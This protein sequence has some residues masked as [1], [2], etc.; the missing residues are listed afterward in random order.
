MRRKTRPDQRYQAEPRRIECR[1][2]LCSQCLVDCQMPFP[3]L[4]SDAAVTAGPCQQGSPVLRI[5]R[6]RPTG[7]HTVVRI[8]ENTTTYCKQM[9]DLG[10][11]R[12]QFRSIVLNPT[13]QYSR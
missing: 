12:F 4:A 11:D 2:Q 8:D 3:V 9:G 13:G 5:K 6:I 7:T 10:S 1:V